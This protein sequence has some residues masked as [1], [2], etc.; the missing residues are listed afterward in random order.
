MGL[1]G[2]IENLNFYFLSQ[3]LRIRDPSALSWM[4]C[5]FTLW[6]Q[7]SRNI[8]WTQPSLL[9]K[10]KP[11][12]FQTDSLRLVSQGRTLSGWQA[13]T[14]G[15]IE[16]Q[17][18]MMYSGWKCPFMSIQK[19]EEFYRKMTAVTTS[20]T[21]HGCLEMITPKHTCTPRALLESFLKAGTVFRWNLCVWSYLL[22]AK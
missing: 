6:K 4:F 17:F 15:V 8:F 16:I 3:S 11:A 18:K 1:G 13:A 14:G 22:Q 9:L 2:E 7:I 5:L 20:R 19:D 10:P 21:D 12:C